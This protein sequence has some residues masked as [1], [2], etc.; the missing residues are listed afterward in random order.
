MRYYNAGPSGLRDL[1]HFA[2]Y[3]EVK[4]EYGDSAVLALTSTMGDF[5]LA[6]TLS[7]C[8]WF[9][10]HAAL[11]MGLDLQ[12]LL[13]RGFATYFA[14][15]TQRDVQ[16]TQHFLQGMVDWS[17]LTRQIQ[18]FY[19]SD[20]VK[21]VTAGHVPQ[22]VVSCGTVAKTRLPEEGW[23]LQQGWMLDGQCRDLGPKNGPFPLTELVAALYVTTS[24]AV[25]LRV[26]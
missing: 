24:F 18:Y 3:D 5:L 7:T 6:W 1:K 4:D 21:D 25:A 9:K 15:F 12:T 26:P 11:D 17:L 2:F 13:E 20:Y 22:H 14:A 23:D 19:S 8:K 16:S 10:D